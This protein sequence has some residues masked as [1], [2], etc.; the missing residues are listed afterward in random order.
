M[1]KTFTVHVVDNQ[2]G[3]DSGTWLVKDIPDLELAREFVRRR[4]RDATEGFREP[5]QSVQEAIDRWRI[6]GESAHVD[7]D[8]WR[9][10]LKELFDTEWTEE[11]R[12]WQGLAR[13]L[14][15]LVVPAR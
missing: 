1:P 4:L 11:E 15:L 13:Q 10:D 2:M 14:G 3:F 9:Y 12:D 6:Y 5:G 8:P 7:G